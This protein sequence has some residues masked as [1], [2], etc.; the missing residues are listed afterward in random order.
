VEPGETVTVAYEK[1]AAGD[2]DGFL[3]LFASF[4]S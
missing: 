3:D 4:W 2:A 1:W